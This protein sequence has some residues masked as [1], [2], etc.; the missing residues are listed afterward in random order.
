M[1]PAMVTIE[2]RLT[3][4]TPCIYDKKSNWNA[5]M[6][7]TSQHDNIYGAHFACSYSF[8]MKKA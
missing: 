6:Y 1:V 3:S 7:T 5:K 4:Q 2:L 8:W